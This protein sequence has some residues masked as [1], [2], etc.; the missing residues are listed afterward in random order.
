MASKYGLTDLRAKL[1]NWRASDKDHL[2]QYDGTTLAS[3]KT[4]ETMRGG[5]NDNDLSVLLESLVIPKL[6]SGRSDTNPAKTIS[7]K[8]DSQHRESSASNAESGQSEADIAVSAQE[9]F[10][11]EDI[12]A[13]AKQAL[14]ADAIDM[15]ASV[16][17]CL[18]KGY[19]VEAIYVNLLAPAARFL[20]TEWENDNCDFV[21]VTMGLWRIQEILRELAEL[22]PPKIGSSHGKRSALFS[23]MVGD[24]HSLGTLMVAECFQRAGWYTDILLD[25]SKSDLTHK[26]AGTYFELL[27]LTL[28][29]ECSANDVN[30]LIKGLRSVSKNPDIVI[31]IGGHQ[32]NANPDMTEQAG[33]DATASDAENAIET[34][35]ALVPIKADV[36]EQFA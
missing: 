19:S 25:P 32:V 5:T 20:G 12:T 10:S 11:D 26:V 23:T 7:T 34:A 13:F 4:G 14:D 1:S 35:E 8:S 9:K 17:K 27:G 22:S 29:A 6:V 21:E 15:L 31:M 3:G 16:E 24:Q 36:F 18:S 28:T 2:N 33:A 30:Q